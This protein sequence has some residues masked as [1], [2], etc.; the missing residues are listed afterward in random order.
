MKQDTICV[1]GSKIYGRVSH[2]N[3]AVWSSNRSRRPKDQRPAW[4]WPCHPT[5]VTG[6][7]FPRGGAIAALRPSS[8]P[9]AIHH[10]YPVKTKSEGPQNEGGV[11]TADG[12]LDGTGR[13]V[14]WNRG[15]ALTP[16]TDSRRVDV[17]RT[18]SLPYACPMRPSELLGRGNRSRWALMTWFNDGGGELSVF[19]LVASGRGAKEECFSEMRRGKG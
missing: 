9:S 7:C 11:H 2:S 8:F 6:V 4:L 1:D 12:C 15:G 3:E 10:S 18:R 14:R 5:P 16:A 19:S 17:A 13:G